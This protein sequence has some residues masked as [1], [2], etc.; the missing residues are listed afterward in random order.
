M[1]VPS[2]IGKG[3][4]QRQP[5]RRSDHADQHALG[6]KHVSHLRLRVP[7]DISTAISLVFSMTIMIR[8]D[9]DVECRDEDDQTDG[10]EGD[11]A[12]ERRAWNRALFCS[13]QLV[14]MKPLPAASS[15]WREI[16]SA[17]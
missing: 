11:Q 2:R 4:A 8:A 3:I 5:N 13:I 12:L 10:D 17:L 14:A 15:S 16:A 6:D 7:I 9:Q 1:I